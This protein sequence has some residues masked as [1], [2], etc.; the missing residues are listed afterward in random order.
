MVIA[1]FAL[2]LEQICIGAAN[3]KTNRL[4]YTELPDI[5]DY[6]LGQNCFLK[7]LSVAWN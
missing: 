1:L 4:V 6:M 2:R 3:T 7:K 5:M